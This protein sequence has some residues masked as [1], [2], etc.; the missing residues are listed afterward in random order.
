MCTC[1]RQSAGVC[2]CVYVRVRVCQGGCACGC[3]PR[4]VHASAAWPSGCAGLEPMM[5]VAPGLG[6]GLDVWTPGASAGGGSPDCAERLSSSLGVRSAAAV[7]TRGSAVEGPPGRPVR[8][9]QH[10][11]STAAGCHGLDCEA[12]RAGLV[13]PV[14]GC[15]WRGTQPVGAACKPRWWPRAGG[16]GSR[17]GQ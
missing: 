8:G 14:R 13:P 1:V 9:S 5:Q 2:T 4:R 6:D 7:G 3:V 10:G 15:V 11:A 16:G 17:D 12:A